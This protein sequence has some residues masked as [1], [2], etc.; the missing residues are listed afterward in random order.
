MEYDRV[1]GVGVYDAKEKREYK[2]VNIV[3]DGVGDIGSTSIVD[4]G[5]KE[6]GYNLWMLIGDDNKSNSSG[7]EE[8]EVS[9]VVI[10]IVCI[11]LTI[12]LEK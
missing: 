5:K 11:P 12:E 6:K 8:V 4:K 1:N 2:A 9:V 7:G 10:I 3:V